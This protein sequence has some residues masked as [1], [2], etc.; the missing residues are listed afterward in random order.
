M[1]HL[2]EMMAFAK[3]VETK[4][5]SAA[6]VALSSSKSLVSKQVSALEA[7]LGVRLLNRT[8]RRMSLTEVGAAYYEH[9]ARIAQELDAAAETV[10][11]LQ[12]KPRG[13][14]R[15]TS[16]VIFA[17]M[18][19]APAIDGFM[20]RYPEVEVELNA[21]DR[22]VDMVEEG[23]DLAI[24]ITDH[25]PPSMVAR[26]IAPV[27][28]VTCAA[29]SYLAQHGTPQTPQDLLQHECLMYQGTQHNIWRYRVG[30]REVA[31]P[32]R[33][34][35]RVNSSEVL[36]QLALAG[37]G[38]VLFPTYVLG[39]YLKS[40]RLVHILAD[41]SANADTDMHA[42]YFPNRYMQPKVRAFIDHL[43][44]HFGEEPSWDKF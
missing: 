8:T 33:G 26:R 27:R 31:V 2:A 11:K 41:S 18:H 20:R 1:E 15:I 25:P 38:I 36:I 44:A 35:C 37:A 30:G 39:P 43:L 14:L 5:F 21:T 4:S 7:A 22:P 10:T 12:A 42:I 13:V 6:A 29:P 24:R 23:F 28:W 34:R 32:V 3:V 17:A 40:G 19:L 16:P 9:C